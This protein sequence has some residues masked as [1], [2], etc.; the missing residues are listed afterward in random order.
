[1]SKKYEKLA[2]DIVEKVGGSENVST[3]THCMTRLRFALNDT[4][5]ADQKRLNRWTVLLMR[6][7]AADNFKLSSAHMLKTFTKK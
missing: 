5:K 2:Q 7:R 4:N 3:L 1:M 6:L